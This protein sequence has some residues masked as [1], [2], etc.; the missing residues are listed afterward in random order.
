[1]TVFSQQNL[2]FCSLLHLAELIH[3]LPQQTVQYGQLPAEVDVALKT[4]GAADAVQVGDLVQE[5]LHG[6]PLHLQE[7]IHEA[8][9][10]L[11]IAKPACADKYS[12]TILY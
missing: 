5:L 11:F 4:A 9:V 8:H 3:D 1:M 6:G 7:L 12:I 10:L 2:N